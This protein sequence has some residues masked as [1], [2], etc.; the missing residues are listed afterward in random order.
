[1]SAERKILSLAV[2][3]KEISDIGL[4][5]GVIVNIKKFFNLKWK[6]VNKKLVF[7]MT[8]LVSI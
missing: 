2:K 1:M 6:V 3:K 4:S 7:W 8:G 5:Y